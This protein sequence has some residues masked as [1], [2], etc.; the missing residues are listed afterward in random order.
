MQKSEVVGISCI[1][2]CYAVTGK[3][4]TL[5]SHNELNPYGCS[6]A[7]ESLANE[8]AVGICLNNHIQVGK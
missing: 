7:A 2:S 8:H 5:L 1:L 3:P 4:F 6:D